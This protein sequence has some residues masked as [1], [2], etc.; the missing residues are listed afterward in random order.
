MVD[1]DL[2]DTLLQDLQTASERDC[3][4]AEKVI[5]VLRFEATHWGA[6][7]DQPVYWRAVAAVRLAPRILEIADR[8]IS[9]QCE[10]TDRFCLIP[11]VHRTELHQAG[12]NNS[13]LQLT[14]HWRAGDF[15]VARKTNTPD[16]ASLIRQLKAAASALEDK[17]ARVFLMANADA[18]QFAALRERATSDS[19]LDNVYILDDRNETLRS[20]TSPAHG[21]L[22]VERLLVEVAMAL[23]SERFIGTEIS[24]VRDCAEA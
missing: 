2:I 20:L 7:W 3:N 21:P 18:V 13:R 16:A 10:S 9:W 15:L 8:V 24:T 4:D 23:R 11:L 12:T 22:D 14:V 1:E 6:Y 17:Q 19:G 5:A